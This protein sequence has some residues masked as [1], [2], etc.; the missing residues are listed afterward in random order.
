MSYRTGPTITTNGLVLCLDAAS[1]KSYP[2]AGTTLTDLAGNGYTGVLAA[3]ALFS[4]VNAGVITLSGA[5]S[6][7]PVGPYPVI[8]VGT[9]SFT[10]EAWLRPLQTAATQTTLDCRTGGGGLTAP[11]P[12]QDTTFHYWVGTTRIN[13]VATIQT[14]QWYH[15]VY[16]RTGAAVGIQ[17]VNG[18]VDGSWADTVNYATPLGL[19]IGGD[20]DGTQF[21]FKGSVGAVRVYSGVGLTQQQVI[22]NFNAMRGRYGV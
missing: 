18:R 13:G 12:F 6:V 5:G 4:P 11:A 9:G 14:G 2:G 21:S 20:W 7:V 16:S 1:T 3:G 17:F 19:R 10:L 22:G 8:T 15:Y